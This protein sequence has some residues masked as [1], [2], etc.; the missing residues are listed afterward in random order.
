MAPLWLAD[1]TDPGGAPL[2][3]YFQLGGPPA[4]HCL[5]LYRECVLGG[6]TPLAVEALVSLL[7]SELRRP[8]GRRSGRPPHW[9]SRARDAI[10]AALQRPPPLVALATVADVHPA[11]LSRAFRQY[12]GCSIGEYLQ[13][14]RVAEACRLLVESDTPLAAIAADVGYHDQSHFTRL[15]RS[16]LGVTPGGYR[17]SRPRAVARGRRPGV[18]SR[19]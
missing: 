13:T 14:R 15:F 6:L 4:W 10:D 5:Q 16:R 18:A 3:P 11:H 19:P 8:S 12:Y 9:L 17:R 1:V 2:G 7:L